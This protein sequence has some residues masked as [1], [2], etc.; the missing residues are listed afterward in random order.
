MY[1]LRIALIL[2]CFC[3]F[4][5]STFA[6]KK[7]SLLSKKYAPEKLRE[8]AEIF[9]NVM[10]AMHPAIGLY[11][12]RN[13]YEKLFSHFVESI[14]DS[15]TEKEF[16]LRLKLVV[17]E[18]HCGHTEVLYSRAFYREV[19]KLKLNFSP[20]IFIPVDNKVYLLANLNRQKDSSIRNGAEITKINGIAVDSMLRY[21]RR[22]ISSDGYNVTAKDHYLQ[23]GFN[24]YYTSLFGRPDT[25]QVEFT[26]GETVK[27][28]KYA[29]FK[30]KSLPVLPL[31]PREDSLCKRF[32]R[33]SMRY[34]FLDDDHKTMLL[35]IERFSN[36]HDGIAYRKIF[37]KM[38]RNK[39]ENLVL[40]LRN[41]GGGSL[42]NAYKLLSYL[43][44]STQS[45][46]LRTT[47]SNYPYRKY[48]SGNIW[49]KFTRL[50]YRVIGEHYE[51]NDTDYFVYRIR[52]RKRNSFHG[53][54]LV[55]VNGGSFSASSLVSAYLKHT[56][57]AV[58]IGEETGGT[59]E[60]CN[61]GITP[62]YK[63][64]NTGIRV[65][66]P[67]FRIVHDVTPELT[68]RGIQPEHNIKYSLN[69]IRAKR[70]L[71]LAMAKKLLGI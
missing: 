59:A 60:G 49:F 52:P 65:R 16:R 3:S 43:I 29:A 55:L 6:Q 8:D 31:G 26:D 14:Q 47:I 53:K 70:D 45:Q 20:Y 24:T 27:N 42:A 61:A 11:K 28:V 12:P 40:D 50:A 36:M 13:Y 25:F 1:F 23:L 22:F 5:P 2:G 37:R 57:R 46:T 19:K 71:E 18:L 7:T 44:D 35:K 15:L 69:D 51:R 68:G 62:Y 34:R 32:K 4:L 48:T 67:A 41:N 58:F 9:R 63:L 21:S 30:P 38:R 33:A 39:S 10:L 56:G 17:D 64:P 66:M 54:M